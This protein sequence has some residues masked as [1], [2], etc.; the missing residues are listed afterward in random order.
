M[1]E[2]RIT[3]RPGQLRLFP[4]I[5]MLVL[6]FLLLSAAGMVSAQNVRIIQTNSQS[7][8]IHLIDPVTQSIVGEISGIP[9]NH[10]VAASP[11]GSRLYF[12]SE[13]KYTLDV[14]DGK[15]FEII[16]EIPLSGRPNNIT[17]GRDGRYVYVGIME[18][19]GGINV[20]DTTSMKNVRHIETQSR[21]HNPYVT[22]DGKFLVAGTFGGDNNLVVYD[23]ETERLAW[24]LYPKRD[25]ASLEGIRPIAFETNADGSTKRMFVQISDLHGFAVVDFNEHREV[26]RIFLPEVPAAEQDPGPYN[27]A[28]AHGIGVAPDGRTLWVCSRMNG[29]VYAYSLPELEYLGGVSVGSHP[30]WLTFSPDSKFV[31]VANGHSDDVSVVDIEAMEEVVRLPVGQAPKRNITALLP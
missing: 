15:T 28:P 10:G 12:S 1:I 22:P 2:E 11:D 19:P 4:T 29:H 3:A 8:I 14:V 21:V 24:S 9:V 6:L 23:I 17:I 20:I 18:D 5:R 25:E 26:D 30:D 31:Y 27:R 7:D 13:A 16:E